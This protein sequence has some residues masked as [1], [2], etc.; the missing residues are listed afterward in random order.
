MAA[1]PILKSETIARALHAAFCR[2]APTQ[3]LM[4][5]AATKMRAAGSPY[6][7]IYFYSVA[8]SG[9]LDFSAY[10]GRPADPSRI[11]L[12]IGIRGRALAEKA[13]FN[14]PDI[15]DIAHHRPHSSETQSKLV[16]LIRRHAEILGEIDVECDCPNG[17]SRAEQNAVEQVADALA[18]LI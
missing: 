16:V 14:V 13:N 18:A 15:S 6:D 10:A 1:E 12:T 5:I 11:S 4:H 2:G 9:D 3:E 17:F 7:S 8:P